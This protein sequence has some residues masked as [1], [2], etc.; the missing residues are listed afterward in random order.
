LDENDIP[1]GLSCALIGMCAGTELII[2]ITPEYAFGESGAFNGDVPPN[3]H[4]VYLVTIL[5]ASGSPKDVFPESQDELGELKRQPSFT[6]NKFP[7]RLNRVSASLSENDDL[8][9]TDHNERS[10]RSPPLIPRRDSSGTKECDNTG[11]EHDLIL[12]L[13]K[14]IDP[15]PLPKREALAPPPIPVRNSIKNQNANEETGEFGASPE[16]ESY[17]MPSRESRDQTS[18]SASITTSRSL[19]NCLSSIGLQDYIPAFADLGLDTFDDFKFA[20]PSDFENMKMKPIHKRKLRE[21]LKGYGV[22]TDALMF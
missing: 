6:R 11:N 2:T 12:E 20:Q 5:T 3:T 1:K 10:G 15:L 22:N 14:R 18:V 21:H 4:V 7:A 19:E 16:K 8:A 9:V 13:R 17:S